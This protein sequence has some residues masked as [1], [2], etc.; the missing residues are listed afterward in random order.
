ML[1]EIVAL[2]LPWLNHG[3]DKMLHEI[4]AIA[5]TMAKSQPKQSVP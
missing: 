5:F 1:H 4:V 2:H 3:L